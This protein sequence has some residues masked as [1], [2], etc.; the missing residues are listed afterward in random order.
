[1][2]S[3]D[4]A[5]RSK[6]VTFTHDAAKAIAETV[7]TVQGGSRNQSGI[8]GGSHAY[9]SSHYLSKTT[10]A[11]AKGTSQTL[12]LYVGNGGSETASSGDTVL[13]WNKF[14]DVQSGK[15]VMLARANGAFYLIAAEC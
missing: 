10:G 9:A 8:S 1:M 4:K 13:A 5:T 7:R 6:G 3:R 2:A 11:W 15:W 12:T 14:S